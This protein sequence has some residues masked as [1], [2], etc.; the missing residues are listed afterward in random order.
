MPY[1]IAYFYCGFYIILYYIIMNK[2]DKKDKEVIAAINSYIGSVKTIGRTL[3]SNIQNSLEGPNKFD[4]EKLSKIVKTDYDIVSDN[5]I[6]TIEDINIYYDNNNI[7][8]EFVDSEV[9]S[10]ADYDPAGRL[11]KSKKKKSKK[12]KSKK[13]K[14][15]KKNKK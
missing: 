5:L 8:M 3:K 2:K 7:G 9:L 13:K 6:K 12:K 14:S 15:K 1:G 11:R 4:L 10:S